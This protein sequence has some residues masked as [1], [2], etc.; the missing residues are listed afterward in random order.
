MNSLG[1]NLLAENKIKDAIELFKLNVAAYPDSWNVYDSL[2]E[3][4]LKDGQTDLAVKNYR[5]SL[6]LNPGNTN[7]RKILKNLEE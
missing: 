7:A 6:E 3:A 1:Y 2:G 5:K 4:Y